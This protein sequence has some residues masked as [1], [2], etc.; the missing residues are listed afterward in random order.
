[1]LTGVLGNDTGVISRMGYFNTNTTTPFDSN[2]DGVYI[3]NNQGTFS[4]GYS[5]NGTETLVAQSDFNID[6]M[7]GHCLS[8]ITLDVTKFQ[9]YFIDFSWLGSGELRFGVLE[10]GRVEYF[11]VLEFSN[12]ETNVWMK[13][14]NH[15]VRAEIRAQA[16][17]T[18]ASSITRACCTVESE[19]GSDEGLFFTTAF[20]NGSTF[21]NANVSGSIYLLLAFRLKST[22]LDRTILLSHIHTLSKT[23]DNLEWLILWNPTIDSDS[24]ALAALTYTSA[25][26]YS[27]IEY[28]VGSGELVT[29]VNHAIDQGYTLASESAREDVTNAVRIGAAIDGTRD[30]IVLAARPLSSNLDVFGGAAVREVK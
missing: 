8:G 30:I 24:D 25:S 23:N 28:A 6:K 7:N 2:R 16:G 3:C 17:I 4:V 12:I 10:E 13:S 22:H 26:A 15:S 18:A 5:K 27:S 9:L 29:T 21:V 14:P 1:M 20:S 19:G 11:H